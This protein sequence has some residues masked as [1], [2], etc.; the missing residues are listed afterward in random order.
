M[1]QIKW[2]I[3]L[4]NGMHYLTDNINQHWKFNQFSNST[5]TVYTTDM[6]YITANK[7]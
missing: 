6:L 2:K 4:Q 3:F 7:T 1:N 5:Y